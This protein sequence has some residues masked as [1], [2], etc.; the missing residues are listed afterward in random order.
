MP[1]RRGHRDAHPRVPIA[2][3]PADED[4]STAGLEAAPDIRHGGCRVVEEHDSEAREREVVRRGKLPAARRTASARRSQGGFAASLTRSSARERCQTQHVARLTDT[5]REG[6]RGRAHPHPM[7]MA[8]LAGQR[9]PS[10]ASPRSPQPARACGRA[11]PASRPNRGPHRSSSGAPAPSSCPPCRRRYRPL[12]DRGR[13]EREQAPERHDPEAGDDVRSLDRPRADPPAKER[14]AAGEEQEPAQ[15]AGADPARKVAVVATE[16]VTFAAEAAANSAA[17]EAIVIGFDAVAKSATRNARPGD[18][19]SSVASPPSRI[20]RAD[21]SVLAP[22]TTSTVAPTN[23]STIR[24]FCK[25][26]QLARSPR[27]RATRR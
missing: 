4:E 17:Q 25:V 10:P 24:S 5:P 9:R 22:S 27:R 20:R 1:Q 13:A 3:L 19:T 18:W 15:A 16:V 8:R 23:P 11:V 6:D 12:S 26:E 21:Q 14:H 7:S 2:V